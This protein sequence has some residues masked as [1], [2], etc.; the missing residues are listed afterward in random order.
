MQQNH[1]VMYTVDKRSKIKQ[2]KFARHNKPRKSKILKRTQRSKQQQNRTIKQTASWLTTKKNTISRGRNKTAKL[3]TTSR[4]HQNEI[5]GCL[6]SHI[7][8]CI[9]K[10]AANRTARSRPPPRP[11][12][13]HNASG[14][15]IQLHPPPPQPTHSA[16]H[17]G[18]GKMC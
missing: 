11:R 8:H 6:A 2:K 5:V 17:P 18:I 13:K 15:G 10:T 14:Q 3:L 4:N 7:H 12:P 1:T 16:K 9:L